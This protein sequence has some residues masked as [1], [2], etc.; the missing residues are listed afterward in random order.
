V[1]LS[2]DGEIG[3][4]RAFGEKERPIDEPHEQLIESARE[5]REDGS[6]APPAVQ[7]VK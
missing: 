7:A 6:W 5:L 1:H 3:D 4:A 2:E